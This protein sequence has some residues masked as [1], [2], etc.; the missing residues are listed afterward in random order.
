MTIKDNFTKHAKIKFGKVYGFEL[1]KL[2]GENTIL[3]IMRGADIGASK[4]Y[5]VAK[6]L[7]ITVEELVTGNEP[8][9]AKNTIAENQSEYSRTDDTT[10]ISEPDQTFGIPEDL[11][12]VRIPIVTECGANTDL[13]STAFYPCELPYEYITFENCKSVRVTGKSMEPVVLDGQRIIFSKTDQVNNGDTAFITLM[14][15]TQLFKKY[16]K[17]EKSGMIILS[18]VN[19]NRYEPFVIKEDQIEFIY[20]VVGALY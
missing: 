8:S 15:G 10:T 1:K 4:A 7:N 6:A 12:S 13:G 20:K 14:G 3:S 16:H 9:I 19:Q 17:D 18:S 5:R 2:V 11:P